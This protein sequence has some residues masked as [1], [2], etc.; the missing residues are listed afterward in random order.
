M[1]NDLLDL[2]YPRICHGC[3]GVL[4]KNEHIICSHCSFHLPETAYHRYDDNPVARLFWGRVQ[5]QAASAYLHFRKKSRVQN[6]LH[7]LKYQGVKEIGQLLGRQYACSLLEQK[8]FSSADIVIPVPLHKA[9]LKARGYNQSAVFGEGLAKGMNKDFSD[10]LLCRSRA[11]ESQT[12]KSRLARF[13]NVEE[14]F[15]ISRPGELKNRH[16]LLVDDVVTTGATLESCVQVLQNA[17][18]CTV[19]IAT[20]AVAAH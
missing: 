5:L 1:L 18:A 20:I 10:T 8:C 16:V 6:L 9:R 2:F 12:R 11:T 7:A 14:V 13:D 15:T 19:S 3:H 4:L 17:A